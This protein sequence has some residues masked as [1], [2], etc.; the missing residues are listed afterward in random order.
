MAAH[1]GDRTAVPNLIREAQLLY[2]QDTDNRNP[3]VAP[4]AF[5][6]SC[7]AFK[8]AMYWA[9]KTPG[10]DAE[11]LFSEIPDLDFVLLSSIELAAGALGLAQH[12]GVR[13]EHNPQREHA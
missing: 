11:P 3:N 7:D 5:W 10:K 8:V 9:G 1:R 4:R 12:S 2:A 6:P 13:M